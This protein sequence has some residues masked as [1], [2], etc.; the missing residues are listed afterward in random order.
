MLFFSSFHLLSAITRKFQGV[1]GCTFFLLV[2]FFLSLS[3]TVDLTQFLEI[4]L[5]EGRR[6]REVEILISFQLAGRRRW[7]Q[8]VWWLLLWPQSLVWSG[9]PD[10]EGPCPCGLS[11]WACGWPQKHIGQRQGNHGRKLWSAKATCTQELSLL[12]YYYHWVKL[13]IDTTWQC[14]GRCIS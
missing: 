10:V 5:W 3:Q 8:R 2:G 7:W 13:Y 12:S 6:T 1:P 14:W 11:S 9:L 4:P